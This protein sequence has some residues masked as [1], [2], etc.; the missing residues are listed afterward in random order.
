MVCLV[1]A[2]ELEDGGLG[3]ETNRFVGDVAI[4]DQ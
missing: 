1:E 3:N 2:S 4:F